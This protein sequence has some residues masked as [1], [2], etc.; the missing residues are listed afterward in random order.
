[1]LELI[2]KYSKTSAFISGLLSVAAFA[3]YF[4]IWAAFIG[5]GLLFFLLLNENSYKKLFI[6][7]YFF[8]FAHFAC[9]FSW[10][11]QALLVDINKTGWLYPIAL[12]ASGGFF[13]LFASLSCVC[14]GIAKTTWNRWGV[15]C[16]AW[17]MSEWLRSF[18]F[19]GFPWNLLGY[20]WGFSLPMM[21]NA[22]VGGVYL[23]SLFAVMSYSILGVLLYLPKKQI[24]LTVLL[25]E[26]VLYGGN[27][28]FGKWRL[29]NAKIEQT[30]TLVR[31]VQPSIPQSMKWSREISEENFAKYLNLSKTET[32]NKPNW[33][34]WGETASPF[35]LDE[36]M[37][38]L[39]MATNILSD[40]ALL[41]SGMISRH[42]KDGKYL[43]HNSMLVIAK[44][45]EV[46]S[47]YHKSHLVP[48][49][50]YIPLREY[51][52]KFIQPIANTI[53][54]FG[55][56]EGAKTIEIYPYPK[57]SG[58]IC[59]E[60]IFPHKIID[61]KNR[62]DVIINL[63]NDG[64][65]GNS[66]GPYQHWIITKFRAIEEGVSVLRVANNG[67]SGLINAVGEEK[68]VLPLNYGGISDVYLEK[69]DGFV[70]IYS[71]NGNAPVIILCLLLMIFCVI[72]RLKFRCE[73]IS[74]NEC[75]KN[76]A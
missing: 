40:D 62:P 26:I 59:Y 21:Q 61:E 39:Y 45:G 63:T 12:L 37:E 6:I 3:P 8:G 34:V 2:K 17:V 52:P 7:G 27:Y 24:L 20:T 53:G 15:F 35:L 41:I 48:F 19:T 31:I 50:E 72:S 4:Q 76:R 44:N 32:K 14:C 51:L 38:H 18:I 74:A 54:E 36:D 57:F 13:G 33:I 11:G 66:A 49:G 46:K 75:K 9:G 16:A 29:L 64:W 67:I 55:K 28:A 65:Y 1:M 22:S 73:G 47:Y 69:T 68:G 70:T 25:F 30:E 56:G 43:P 58:L 23:T 60:I 10:V 71:R 5:F 42:Y